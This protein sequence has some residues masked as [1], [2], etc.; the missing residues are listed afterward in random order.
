MSGIFKPA[1]F[2]RIGTIVKVDP[3]TMTATVK[4]SADKSI[5]TSE[6]NG[7][8]AQLPISFLSSGGGFIGGH[9]AGGTPVAVS[10]AEGSGGYF[11]VAFLARA[12]SALSTVSQSKI[13]IPELAEGTITIQSNTDGNISLD[14]DGI[15]IG[16]PKNSVVF[17]TTDKIFL[18]NFDI[19]YSISQGTRTI[20]GIIKR[21]R[22]PRSNFAT[23]LTTSDISYDKMLKKI[24]MD[25]V[26]TPVNSNLGGANRNPARIENRELILEYEDDAGVQSN[27]I[28]IKLYDINSGIPPVN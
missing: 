7:V 25:P 11:I 15:T 12:P 22:M 28:E 26:A 20:D 19:Q 2:I 5:G 13:N 9:V 24:G 16:E 4:F 21:D 8:Q 14:N 3:S 23:S 1:G 17:D 6:R 27:D 10:Q 18:N